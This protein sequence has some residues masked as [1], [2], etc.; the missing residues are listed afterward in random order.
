MNLLDLFVKIGIDDQATD[1]IGG[2]S[3]RVKGGLGAAA[4][5]GAAAIGTAT[6]AAATGA[7]ALGKA[8]L[9]SYASYEQLSGGVQKLFGDASDA[10]MQNAQKA[11]MTSGMSANQYMEQATSFSAALIGS[12]GGDTAK[13]AE[14]ADVAMRAISDNVNVFGSD[15]GSVQTA[16]QGFAKQNY[17]ML[18]NLKLGYGGT[19]EE[20]ERL[21]ADANE[22]GAANGKASDLSIESFSDVVT[23]I[24]Q[25]QEKQG[26]AGT[27]AKEAATTIE[28]SIAATQAAWSNLLTELGKDDGD[29]GARMTELV[30]SVFGDGTEANPGA[31][32][33]ILPRVEQIFQSVAD[34]IPIMMPAIQS[35]LET[36]LP[37][38]I[39]AIETMAPLMVEA[40]TGVIEILAQTLPSL[41]SSLIPSIVSMLPTILEAGITLFMGLLDALTQSMPQIID[42]LT[43]ALVT[44]ISLL[45]QYLPQML[46]AGVQLF[47]AIITALAQNLPEI[48]KALGDA[49][50]ELVKYVWD[51]KD[52][53]LKAGGELLEGLFEAI[54]GAAEGLMK[55]IG[56]LIEDG[57]ESI[58]N[59]ID[60]M[61]K[62]GGELIQG[63]VDGIVGAPADIG[64]ALMDMVGDGVD[65]V[66]N[67]LGIAS[68]SKLFRKFGN[69]TMEGFAKGIEQMAG[70]AERA[71]QNAAG[72]VY[73]A[74][75]GEVDI[76]S[77]FG[78][79]ASYATP[80]GFAG[81][82]NGIVI[83]L[84]YNA[85]ADAND[86]L[87]DIYRGVTQYRV[88][89]VM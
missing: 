7:A 64:G 81:A 75:S 66:K 53:M 84:N 11:Y 31:F 44:M 18:D 60:D 1:K 55:A 9:D 69:Y 73:D 71:M 89:G 87:R 41:L 51:N 26:I 40:A 49:I 76:Y 46:A 63:L 65:A 30:N 32:G 57:I 27:T 36:A 21:I 88:A 29:I 74:A 48:L 5:A 67:F 85:G 4:K 17:T 78:Q 59:F 34:S 6:A 2:I 23:A 25:I 33:N 61:L 80:N 14:Q 20:M 62:A 47:F 45:P 10:M 52:E 28:G 56:D 42:G 77:R 82:S 39:Q 72:R 68:P 37:I 58:G 50:A 8:A 70:K 13:A 83:N 3:E 16:F 15:M 54:G 22:W 79:T 38:V 19:K 43:T 24:Q 86:M 35:A 12:L